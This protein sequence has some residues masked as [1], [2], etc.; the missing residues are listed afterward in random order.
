VKWDNN[1][2]ENLHGYDWEQTRSPGGAAQWAPKNA[3]SVATV[4]DAHDPSKKHAPMMFTT[5]ISLKLEPIY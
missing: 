5:D 2:F 3:A 4:P 1:Y